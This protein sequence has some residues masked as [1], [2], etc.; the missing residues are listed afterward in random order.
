MDYLF[1][2]LQK[3]SEVD[4][5]ITPVLQMG[6]LRPR[7]VEERAQVHTAG[8]WMHQEGNKMGIRW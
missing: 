3:P 4:V 1:E 5:I 2:S 6:K 7:E 8:E